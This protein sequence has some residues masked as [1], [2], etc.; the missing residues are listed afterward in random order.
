MAAMATQNPPVP[1]EK[2]GVPSR[3]PLP[4]SASQ[5]A[6]VRDIFYQKVRKECAE[7]IKGVYLPASPL[8]ESILCSATICHIS[9]ISNTTS[10]PLPH[11]LSVEHSQSP[12]PAALNTA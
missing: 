3:N 7:E 12:S 9:S 8:R 10:Q 4:L 5:E 1:Q 11:A 6:Q 2:L